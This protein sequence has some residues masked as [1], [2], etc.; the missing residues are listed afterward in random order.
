M[1]QQILETGTIGERTSG[2][3]VE[4]GIKSKELGR[5]HKKDGKEIEKCIEDGKEKDM[6]K[7]ERKKRRREKQQSEGED[8]IVNDMQKIETKKRRDKKKSKGDFITESSVDAKTGNDSTKSKIWE[9][10][11]KSERMVD[12][13]VEAQ[14]VWL[15]GSSRYKKWILMS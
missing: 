13:F 14:D 11:E 5:K 8:Y 7:V 10:E 9:S 15:T 12:R 3:E 6:E 2:E 1:D 4:K